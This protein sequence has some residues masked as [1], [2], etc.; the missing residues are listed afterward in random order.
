MK[1]D[2]P[3]K[4]VAT[5]ESSPSSS[6]IEDEECKLGREDNED[7]P[8]MSPVAESTGAETDDRMEESED[9]GAAA[10]MLRE[11]GVTVR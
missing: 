7:I 6:E 8:G 4:G 3:L 1:K 2:S 10:W 9:E 5:S 11:D